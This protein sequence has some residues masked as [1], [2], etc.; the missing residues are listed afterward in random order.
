MNPQEHEKR[1]GW[2]F[3]RVRTAIVETAWDHRWDFAS[4][5]PGH[6]GRIVR[7]LID[8]GL[9]DAYESG[10]LDERKAVIDFADGLAANTT[11]RGLPIGDVRLA[12]A[13]GGI[14]AVR[15]SIAEGKHHL[16]PTPHPE[17]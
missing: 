11:A 3:D 4:Q 16:K 13:V 6:L 8:D 5:K 17:D 10:K 7:D 1:I 2:L 14:M 15:K 9:A 12:Q